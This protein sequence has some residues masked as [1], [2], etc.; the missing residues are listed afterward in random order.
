MK[1]NDGYI[2]IPAFCSR[3]HLVILGAGATVDANPNGDRNGK[4]SSVMKGFVEQLGF[5]ELLAN[6]NIQF[7]SDNLEDIYSTFAE[8][9]ECEGVRLQLETAI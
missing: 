7:K 8:R 5:S 6:T 2:D 4:K 9:K 3:P 1:E